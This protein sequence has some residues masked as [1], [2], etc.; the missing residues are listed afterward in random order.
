MDP[1]LLAGGRPR[2]ARGLPAARPARPVARRRSLRMPSAGAISPARSAGWSP[3]PATRSPTC[4]GV[5]VGHSQAESGERTGVTVVAPPSLPGPGG[6]ADHER[7]GR[8]HRQAGDRGARRDRDAG[9]PV[10]DACARHRLRGRDRA[11]PGA[12]P[13]DVIIPVVGECDDGDM[14]DS[15]TITAATSSGRS[16]RSGPRWRRARWAPARAWFVSSSRAGSAPPR[17]RGP[18]PRRRAAAVQ[19]RRAR[20]P[21][22][23]G[24]SLGPAAAR[25]SR[26]IV[27]HRLRDRRS[28]RRRTSSAASPCGRCSGSRGRAPTRP[29]VRARSGW[30]SPPAASGAIDDSSSTPT[31]GRLGGRPRG[32]PQLPGR[33]PPGRAPRRHDAGR[34]PGRARSARG[35][36]QIHREVEEV[37]RPA[38]GCRRGC[39]PRMPCP[40]PLKG[41]DPDDQVVVGH[42]ADV[43]RRPTCT[44]TVG[45]AVPWKNNAGASPAADVVRS[46]GSAARDRDRARGCPTD[47]PGC[48]WAPGSSGRQPTSSEVTAP[49]DSPA[50]AMRS[51]STPRK[52]A[53]CAQRSERLPGRR[54]GRRRR[55]CSSTRGDGP[56]RR[57][58]GPVASRR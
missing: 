48:R 23:L 4:P 13:S 37:A 17:E 58:R 11:P 7:D 55:R 3:A 30:R 46:I 12:G 10:R 45:S 32:G 16:R 50:I 34:V 14:A 19:L 42:R 44:G 29:R 57:R 38:R 36:R 26:G 28:A 33:G 49:A 27:H 47:G 22:R 20:V 21:R 18:A 8:A 31:S 9:L 41:S 53:F 5:R 52:V 40:S 2:S 51:G 39:G 24:T 25:R 54:A 15:R 35:V 43:S 1:P 6:H 56:R